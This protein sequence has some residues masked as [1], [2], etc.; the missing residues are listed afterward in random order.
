MISKKYFSESD[1]EKA[2]KNTFI[3]I[4]ITGKGK[5]QIIKFLTGDPNA[6]VSNN[7]NSCTPYSSLYYGAIPN[8]ANSEELF[9]MIDTAGLCDSSGSD[10][11]K[12]NYNDIKNVLISNK[13]E[14]KGIFIIENF[15]DE[16][17]DGEERKVIKAASDL[18][19]LQKFWSYTTIIFTHYY[20]KGSTSKI[21]IKKEQIGPFCDSL[22]TIM[23]QVKERIETIDC[24]DVNSIDKI[25]INVDNNVIE[26]KGFDLND[27]DDKDLYEQGLK[28]LEKAKKE[29]HTE[30]LKKIKYEPLYDEVRDRGTQRF[31]IRKSADAFSYNI[32]EVFIEI[33]NFYLKKKLI[34]T[35]FIFVK[36]PEFKEN[37]NKAKFYLEKIGK[38]FLMAT[39]VV[40]SPI[41]KGVSLFY[42][43]KLEIIPVLSRLYEEWFPNETQKEYR[44]K[45]Y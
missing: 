39:V 14:V 45:L 10:Q 8:D 35:D 4:G 12:K 31:I 18:F 27:E 19:P 37:I 9:C 7:K 41:L 23:N 20:N 28:D 36:N 16:R 30:I 42:D 17:L 33:R 26:K 6:K 25:Y 29:L 5:S 32:Y 22:K 44:T 21:Q 3:L 1:K 2:R 13:C 15:Q 11:D 34:F 40:E 24:I 43:K 38:G